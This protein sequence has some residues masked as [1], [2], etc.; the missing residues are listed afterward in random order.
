MENFDILE[1]TET[2]AIIEWDL[3]LPTPE[4]LLELDV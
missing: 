3:E 4:E 1:Y 2:N